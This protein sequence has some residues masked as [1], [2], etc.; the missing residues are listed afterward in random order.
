MER[1]NIILKT[2]SVVLLLCSFVVPMYN[3]FP[4]GLIVNQDSWFFTET[5]KILFQ[6][7]GVG[8]FNYLGVVFHLAVWIPAIIL[9][10]GS[11]A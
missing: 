8:A 4:N 11:F 2:V 1:K 10:I 7:G 5:F 6:E 3:I 9:Y